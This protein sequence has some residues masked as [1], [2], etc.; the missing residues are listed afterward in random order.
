MYNIFQG[1]DLIK[2]AI[3]QALG[4]TTV[5]IEEYPRFM[6]DMYFQSFFYL[7]KRFGSP[8]AFDKG[9][10]AG[11]WSF[12]VKDFVIQIRLNGCYVEFMVY[13]KISN[14]EVHSPY[15]VK[16]RRERFKKRELLLNEEGKW[17]KREEEI[18]KVL[19]ETFST[20]NNIDESITAE[21]FNKQYGMKW[22]K[23]IQDYN[24]R[25]A[26]VDYKEIVAK[27]GDTYQNSYTRHAIRALDQFLKNMLTP[28]W[29]RDVPYNI[30]G[31]LT[32]KEADYYR[33]YIDNVKIEAI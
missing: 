22:F 31:K 17:D 26:N 27:Y 3:A 9:K 14:R 2:K 30:K 24:D 13:G 10:E 8:S 32:D 16:Y 15:I 1:N 11:A 4:Y 28:I 12:K 5:D 6:E 33:R 23:K 19:F 29:I 25:I 20:E 7:S 18:A 21:Q